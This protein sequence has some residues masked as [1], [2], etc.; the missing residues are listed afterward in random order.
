MFLL[1]EIPFRNQQIL[2][3]AIFCN[4]DT[5]AYCEGSTASRMAFGEDITML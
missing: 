5:T 1:M 4:N 3:V 2:K